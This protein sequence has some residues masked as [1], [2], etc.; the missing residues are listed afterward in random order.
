[1][2]SLTDLLF[3][4]KGEDHETFVERLRPLVVGE[5]KERNLYGSPSY[6]GYGGSWQDED[7]LD[8]L[9]MDVYTAIMARRQALRAQLARRTDLDPMIRRNVRNFFNDRQQKHDPLGFR[10]YQNV[11]GGLQRAIEAGSMTSGDQELRGWSLCEY[12]SWRSD[13][14]PA[15]EQSLR[16]AVLSQGRE[17]EFL[18]GLAEISEENKIA[19]EQRVSRV[20]AVDPSIEGF[21]CRA[22][23]NPLK[24]DVRAGAAAVATS[25]QQVG[26][27]SDPGEEGGRVD[28][29]PVFTLGPSM[30]LFLTTGKKRIEAAPI[31]S[32]M[33]ANLVRVLSDC[34]TEPES[35]QTERALRL[36]VPVQTLSDWFKRL[37]QLLGGDA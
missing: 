32:A 18:S 16:A 1:M 36:M 19:V 21:H 25:D 29:V 30:H 28:L 37:R 2:T 4:D 26:R 6:L 27:E 5:L 35:P 8:D 12:P 3:S 23:A 33:K 34:A 11:V 15:D 22:L 17:V 13:S 7:R 31:A 9:V 24:A 20:P 10:V 14:H